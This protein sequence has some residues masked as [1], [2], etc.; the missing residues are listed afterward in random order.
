M[1]SMTAGPRILR[2]AVRIEK[3]LPPNSSCRS[4]KPGRLRSIDPIGGFP[5]EAKTFLE[6]YRSLQSLYRLE[7]L[8]LNLDQYP[9]GGHRLKPEDAEK[10]VNFLTP[11]AHLYALKRSKS[12]RVFVNR[13]RVLG[14][15]ISSQALCFNLFTDL[16]MGVLQKD[17]AEGRAVKSLFPAL[18]IKK[19]I[20]V[21]LEKLPQIPGF[22]KLA[23]AFDA[24]IV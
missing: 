11:E 21:D 24:V 19:V 1:A 9:Q 18:P 10:G 2:P 13:E 16:K 23:T 20:S 17:P 8:R 4:S 12:W 5:I 22:K 15:L 3:A 7:V 14:N 6:K